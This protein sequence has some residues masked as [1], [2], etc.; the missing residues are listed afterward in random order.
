VAIKVNLTT[1]NRSRYR[2]WVAQL[3]DR[4]FAA[5][6]DAWMERVGRKELGVVMLPHANLISAGLPEEIIPAAN[7]RGLIIQVMAPFYVTLESINYFVRNKNNTRL[8]SDERWLLSEPWPLPELE[9][10]DPV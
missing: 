10:S 3:G 4:E 7:I 8:V 6:M 5:R 1:D 9:L 2:E